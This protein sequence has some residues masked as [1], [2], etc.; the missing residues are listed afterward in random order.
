MLITLRTKF[1]IGFL[2]LKKK[3]VELTDI[4]T[5]NGCGHD[6]QN[7]DKTLVKE[8]FMLD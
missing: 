3:K 6:K 4:E 2:E 5:C 8:W 1:S 7:K